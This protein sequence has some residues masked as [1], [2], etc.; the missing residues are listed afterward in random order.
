M[1]PSL[2]RSRLGF[3]PWFLQDWP[4]GHAVLGHLSCLSTPERGREVGDR[5]GTLLLHV[6]V[7]SSMQKSLAWA[8]A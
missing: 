2:S 6:D 7:P 3:E 1:V 8:G 4:Q 5:L